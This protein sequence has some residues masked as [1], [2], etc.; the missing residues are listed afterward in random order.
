MEINN[1]GIDLCKLQDKYMSK[2]LFC[3]FKELCKILP[4]VCYLSIYIC[5]IE[6]YTIDQITGSQTHFFVKDFP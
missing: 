4:T 3:Y 5:V 1:V 2:L 6:Y